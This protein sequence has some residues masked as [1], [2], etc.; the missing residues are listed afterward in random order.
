M[1]MMMML[2]KSVFLGGF[3][4]FEVFDLL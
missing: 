4:T 1:M 2:S 3:G